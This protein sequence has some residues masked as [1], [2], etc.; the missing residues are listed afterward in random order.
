MS[1][2]IVSSTTIQKKTFDV[3]ITKD[4]QVGGFIGE[5]SELHAYSEG[6]TFGQIIE[7]MKEAIELAIA[8]DPIDFNMLVTEQ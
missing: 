7:N 3:V 4:T 5:C 6:D 1:T 8:D 2:I